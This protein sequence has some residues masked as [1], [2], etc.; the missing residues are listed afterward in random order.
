MSQDGG[1]VDVRSEGTRHSVRRRQEAE[2]S[3]TSKGITGGQ[4]RRLGGTVEKPR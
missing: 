2:K 4:G 3:A 1:V